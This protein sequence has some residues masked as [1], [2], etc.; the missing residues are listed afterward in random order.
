MG[1]LNGSVGR[2][3]KSWFWGQKFESHVW[4][5]VYLIILRTQSLFYYLYT[6]KSI[7][8][9][10][11]CFLISRVITRI[12]KI[13]QNTK[14]INNMKEKGPQGRKTIDKFRGQ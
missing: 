6:Y 3:C 1:C 5:R 8:V 11:T 14:L 2:A 13:E 12:Y 7:Y 4:D 9:F 10:A